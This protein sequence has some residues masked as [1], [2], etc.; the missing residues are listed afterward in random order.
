[1][2]IDYDDIWEGGSLNQKKNQEWNYQIQQMVDSYK[3]ESILPNIKPILLCIIL[4]VAIIFFVWFFIDV[5]MDR[6]YLCSKGDL[7]ACVE[8]QWILGNGRR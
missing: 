8:Y 3:D 5:T 6:K 4:V 2:K 1:V 7:S